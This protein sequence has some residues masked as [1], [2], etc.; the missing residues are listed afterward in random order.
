[1]LRK[2]KDQGADNQKRQCGAYNH[3]RV[4]GQL[5]EGTVFQDVQNHQ[6]AQAAEDNQAA[7]NQVQ[8]DVVLI[9]NEALATA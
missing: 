1:M 7:G 6:E 9:R 4:E 2:T 5:P 8:Q 3:L